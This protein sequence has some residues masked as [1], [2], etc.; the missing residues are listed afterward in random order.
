M[1]YY[2]SLNGGKVCSVNIYKHP[3]PSI[4]LGYDIS[5]QF[6]LSVASPVAQW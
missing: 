4:I 3:I 2:F 5:V 1:Q 6:L